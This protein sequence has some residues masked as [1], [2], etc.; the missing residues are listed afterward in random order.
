LRLAY[1][2]D[3]KPHYTDYSLTPYNNE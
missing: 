3:Q 1:D 2:I